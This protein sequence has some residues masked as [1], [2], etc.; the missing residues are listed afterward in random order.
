MKP[1]IQDKG[2]DNVFLDDRY[3]TPHTLVT[4]EYEAVGGMMMIS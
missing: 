2:Y 4:D 1:V 3:R